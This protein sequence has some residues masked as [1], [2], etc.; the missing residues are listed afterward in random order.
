MS[1]TS[2]LGTELDDI[3]NRL[4]LG[5]HAHS[6]GLFRSAVEACCLALDWPEEVAQVAVALEHDHVEHLG[7]LAFNFDAAAKDRKE[8]GCSS[9]WGGR[10]R[11]FVKNAPVIGTPLQVDV[12]DLTSA[13]DEAMSKME[14]QDYLL[15]ALGVAVAGYLV[16]QRTRRP[17]PVPVA[18]LP[19]APPARLILILVVNASRENVISAVRTGGVG[20]LDGDQLYQATQALWVGN[21]KDF[22]RSNLA[23]WFR[24]DRGVAEETEYD[25]HLIRIDIDG[26]D[27]GLHRGANQIDRLDA[28]RRFQTIGFKATVSPRLPSDAYGTTEVYSR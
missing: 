20:A 24:S 21:E 27:P 8:R 12:A 15:V 13:S 1:P 23:E 16:Y 11:N 17:E 3:A 19:T 2:E 25:V 5:R 10:F 7:R 26:D 18:G 14:P 6:A 28:F 4:Q 9:D 22:G